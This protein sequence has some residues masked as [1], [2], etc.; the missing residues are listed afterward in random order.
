MKLLHYN[1]SDESTD[2]YE[3]G[4]V[5][6]V[7]VD[8]ESRIVTVYTKNRSWYFTLTPEDVEKISNPL[9]VY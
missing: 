7:E 2:E 6:D 3:T 4:E 5:V 1:K 9:E 8:K